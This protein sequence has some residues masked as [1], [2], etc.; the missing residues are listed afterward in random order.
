MSVTLQTDVHLGNDCAENFHSIKKQPKRTL[1]QSFNVTEKLI[2]YQKE[3]SG[4][5][6]ICWQQLMW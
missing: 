5:P 6:V 4:I 1:K 2:R 3:I